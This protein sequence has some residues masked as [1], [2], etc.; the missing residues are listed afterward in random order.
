MG[1]GSHR[2]VV[3]AAFAGERL[4]RFLVARVPELSRSRLSQLVDEGHVT[5]D[6]RQAKPSLRLKIAAVVAVEIPPP[7]PA[8]PQPEALG[9]SV[10]YDDPDLVVID[11]PAGMVVH[12]AAGVSSG[13]L[14][15]AL[16]HHVT[17]LA[18]IGGEL[19]PGI[20]HRLDKNT[21]GALVV[22]KNDF[23]LARLQAAFAA[24]HVDKRY[25]AIAHGCPPDAGTIDTWFGRHK[26]DRVR[27]T[28]KLLQ[29]AHGARRA[30][31]HYE[32]RERFGE[33]AARLEVRLETGRTHQIRVHLSEAGFPLLCDATYGGDKR[34]RKALPFVQ[35]AAQVLGRQALHAQVLAFAHPRTGAPIRCE[36]PIPPDLEA[37][38]ARLRRG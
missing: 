4:D 20:V 2:F 6:G 21:S 14:V 29:G 31:T 3:D 28:G 19:R 13:T 18:G 38:L 23:T 1:D 33:A 5:V 30:V 10:L 26:V 15:N 35:E 25:L 34:D 22:A 11:K 32:V 27:M 17:D 16:L 7:A 9:L 24:R 8:T 37:C 12:P 36:A